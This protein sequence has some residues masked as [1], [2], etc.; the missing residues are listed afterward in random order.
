M[1]NTNVSIRC[2]KCGGAIAAE[3]SEGICPK[4]ALAAIATPTETGEPVGE[5]CPVPSLQTVAAAFPQLEI[6]ELIGIGG[7]GAVFK[8]RQPKLERF[9]AL[10]LLNQPRSNSHT[11]AER[12]HR[13][14]RVLARL[15]HPGIVTVYDYGEASGFFYLLMEFVDGVNLRQAMRAGRFT[16]AQA[17]ALVPKICEALQFAHDEGIL[18]RDIKPENIL[19][20]TRGRVKIADFGIAKL[21]G[22]TAEGLSLTASGLA[23]GTPHYMAPE[24]WE[25]PQNVD[26]RA[27]IYSLG[28]VFYELL[29]GEL[30]IGRFEPPSAK[31]PLDPRVDQVVL[32]A[33]EKERERRQ[34]NAT[35][36][37]EQVETIASTPSPDPTPTSGAAP[38][39]HRKAE[40]KVSFCYVSTPA[41]LRSFR[42][43]F[44]NIYEGKGEL[45]LQN[46]TLVFHSGW[47][48]VSIPLAS[49][50]ALAR[51]DYPASAKPVPVSYLGVTYAEHG[52]ER[53]LLFTPATSSLCPPWQTNQFVT[54]W[55]ADLQAAIADATGHTLEIERSRS[56]EN[57]S[58][59]ELGKSFLLSAAG[60]TVAFAIIPL[61]TSQRL[62]NSWQE[63]VWGPV[64]AAMAMGLLLVA[65]WWRMHFGAAT[66]SVE[67]TPT[68]APSD[69]CR[70]PQRVAT[71][72]TTRPTAQ[73]QIDIGS[74]GSTGDAR[75]S[76]CYFSTP[77]RM[78]HCFPGPQ[79]HIFLCKGDLALGAAELTFR[80]PWQTQV[81]IPLES[82]LDLSIGQFQMWTT[83]W[84]M[85]NTSGSTFSR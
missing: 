57:W 58:W 67:P 22:G 52:H 1:T 31:T 54:E 49:I 34:R 44:I 7:M 51:G 50:R 24:Q 48:S 64:T 8:A 68:T 42:G 71:I 80:T 6:V 17:L 12:F 56:A 61:I 55:T 47:Q 62:P 14:A 63:L 69:Q 81:L 46:G 19:L 40:P 10:K 27:D 35:E 25:Q 83:A 65:R 45:R 59:V 79:A 11:F 15:N 3:A 70:Q 13:E 53:S 41:Y 18:H 21:I 37:K 76:P 82:I 26:Q 23:V 85:K 4:C 43:R 28:V 29:T 38:D 73:T 75:K 16:A 77:E 66:A 60:C 74:P 39:K 36:V 9:V 84:V 30:P 33:L 20:D 72:E 2:P 78:R 5:R 32:R